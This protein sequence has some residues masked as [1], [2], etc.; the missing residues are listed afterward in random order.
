MANSF[1][2]AIAIC[3]PERPLVLLQQNNAI[4]QHCKIQV[5]SDLMYKL[6]TLP[7]TT[8][9]HL[10]LYYWPQ[11]HDIPFSIFPSPITSYEYQMEWSAG[12]LAATC[13][14]KARKELEQATEIW[15]SHVR[16]MLPTAL[17]SITF[18]MALNRYYSNRRSFGEKGVLYLL[19]YIP[20][21]VGVR[22]YR[23][24]KLIHMK[25]HMPFLQLVLF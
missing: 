4:I 9:T 19:I 22:Y 7:E 18:T 24:A 13:C 8:D 6:L 3:K 21:N 12:Y 5:K 17:R 16:R 20:N 10:T 1:T 11:L 14:L 23:K 15:L 25:A 2:G